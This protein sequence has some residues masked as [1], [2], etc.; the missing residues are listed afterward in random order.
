MLSAEGENFLKYEAL[1]RRK[2]HFQ[3]RFNIY[4]FGF[5]TLFALPRYH[6]CL[7]KSPFLNP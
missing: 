4:D 5:P 7:T 6:D 2:W 1:D 3:G